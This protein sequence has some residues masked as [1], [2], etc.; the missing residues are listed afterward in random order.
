[1]ST[2]LE[3]DDLVCEFAAG[4]PLWARLRGRAPVRLRAVDQVSLRVERGTSVGIVG[5]SGC[6]KTTLARAV[7]GL[8]APT[9]GSISLDGVPLIGPRDRLTRR[10]LQMVFQDPGSSLN[11]KLTIGVAI[12]EMIR[13][14]DLR[15][16]ADIDRRCR[17]LIELVELSP[18]MLDQRP[19]SLSGGQRQRAAIARALALEPDLLIA[20]EAVAALDVSVQASILNLL[21]NLRAE[22]GLTMLFISHDLGVVRQVTDRVAVC[23]LGRIVEDQP[24][25]SL[26]DQPQHPYTG[27]LLAVAP[28]LDSHKRPGESAVAG[29]V[30]SPLVRPTGCSFR[31]RCSRASD[32]CEQQ[33]PELVAHAGAGLVACHHSLGEG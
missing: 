28:R 14:H 27:A 11:P 32:T 31:H 17:E 22:L 7:I 6:G 8:V 30:P 25:A 33:I 16:G 26:F 29:E 19:G 10:K 5:E 23:Y 1:M 24:T 3:I 2:I 15:R 13:A 18:T 21:N 20:D 9:S 12:E 4:S